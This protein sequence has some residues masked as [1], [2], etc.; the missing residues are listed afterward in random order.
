MSQEN[1]EV[2]RGML[3]AFGGTQQVP[4]EAFAPDFIWD[5]SNFQGWPGRHEFTGIAEFDEFFAGWIEPYSEWTQ[6]IVDV[7][8][9][10]RDHVVAT[11]RQRGRLRDSGSWVDLNYALLYT[12]REGRIQ[13]VELYTPPEGALKAAGLRA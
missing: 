1:V 7:R 12:F 3:S 2:V 10:G 11:M 8:D 9:A 5:L 4:A 6:E 13:R